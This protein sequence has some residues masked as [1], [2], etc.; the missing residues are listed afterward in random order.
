MELL[1][2]FIASSVHVTI[3][4]MF[5]GRT[6]TL[7]KTPSSYYKMSILKYVH[8]IRVVSKQILYEQTIYIWHLN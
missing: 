8:L 2:I 4:Q 3:I 1:S 5:L 7:L 6:F